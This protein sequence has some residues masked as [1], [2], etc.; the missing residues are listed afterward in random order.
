MLT[1]ADKKFLKEHF[2]TKDDLT[3]M[4]KRQS[5][6]FKEIK[7]S[8][9]EAID[10]FDRQDLYHHKRLAVLEKNAGFAEQPLIPP[11]N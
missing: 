5:K 11:V 9:E 8:L 7:D 4:E 6:K 10:V 2:A 3:S 1:K